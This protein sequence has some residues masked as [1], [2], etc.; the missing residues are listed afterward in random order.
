MVNNMLNKTLL[1][2]I[3]SELKALN[4]WGVSYNK[5][6]FHPKT[7]DILKSN[8][9]SE[10]ASFDECYMCNDS[11]CNTLAFLLTDTDPI[12]IIDYDKC[13]L[14]DGKL[15]KNADNG[16]RTY[17]SWSEIS[18]GGTGI[19]TVILSQPF[20]TK[21]LADEINGN[22]EYY[23][24]KRY[25]C[26]TGNVIGDESELLDC[27]QFLPPQTIKE[28]KI[29]TGNHIERG[30][31]QI[32]HRFAEKIRRAENAKGR[33]EFAYLWQADFLCVGDDFKHG[34]YKLAA[35]IDRYALKD[36]ADEA[37]RYEFVRGVITGN[38]KLRNYQWINNKHEQMT[39][40]YKMQS[41]RDKWGF[42]D[43]LHLV[44]SRAMHHNEA[45][46]GKKNV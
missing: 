2:N 37:K 22:V 45:Y 40:E 42:K 38:A 17:P 26:M 7:G 3:P 21:V 15:L 9:P 41:P 24:S 1:D 8:A 33:F 20:D 27:G 10:W 36:Y 4:Q 29:I 19:H 31:S 16:M 5:L 32:A 23:F 46:L 6:A 12:A 39:G 35:Y 34:I 11:R 44:I 25:I 30:N 43:W 14:A 13:L 18:Q 28:V